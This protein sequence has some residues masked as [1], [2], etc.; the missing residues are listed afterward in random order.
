MEYYRFTVIYPDSGYRGIRSSYYS[1][2]S[3]EERDRL[4]KKYEGYEIKV[5]CSN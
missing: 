2:T 4:F 3:K 1:T 5:H